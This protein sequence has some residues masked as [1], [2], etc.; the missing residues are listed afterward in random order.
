MLAISSCLTG[1]KCRYN[2]TDSYNPRL[3]EGMKEEYIAVCPEILAGFDTPRPPCE[4]IG[5]SGGDVLNGTARMIDK[6][7]ADI[8]G[9]MIHG[10]KKALQICLEKGA[11]KAYLQSRSPTCGCG[12]IYDGSFSNTLKAGDG[13]FTALLKQHNIEIVEVSG[14]A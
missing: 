12:R 14:D 7:G 1:V 2:A 10:A 8:T 6:N 3:M 4:I 13:I 11:A 9:A 5:G